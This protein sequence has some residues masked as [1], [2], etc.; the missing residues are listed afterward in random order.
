VP[1]Q[2][3]ICTALPL[4]LPFTSGEE[5]GSWRKFRNEDLAYSS[6]NA[7]SDIMSV[8]MKWPRFVAQTRAVRGRY[9]LVARKPTGKRRLGRPREDGNIQ[10]NMD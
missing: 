2:A 1:V 10:V 6:P 8:R 4:P 9:T 3:R 5:T 7:I